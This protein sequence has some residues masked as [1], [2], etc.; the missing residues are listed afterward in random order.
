MRYLSV[1]Y[2]MHKKLSK[3]ALKKRS[4]CPSNSVKPSPVNIKFLATSVH[5]QSVRMPVNPC[6]LSAVKSK[7]IQLSVIISR[8]AHASTYAHFP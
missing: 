3:Q 1:L 5:P 6:T 7:Q 4:S 8:H 2:F